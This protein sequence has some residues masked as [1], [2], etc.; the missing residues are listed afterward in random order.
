[1]K[2]VRILGA[3]PAGSIAA[4]AA[5]AEGARVELTERSRYPRH[6]VCGE[7]IS[8][9]IVPVLERLGLMD[10]FAGLQPFRVRRMA[11]HL[12]AREK[13]AVLP[14]RAFGLSRYA[15]DHLL[16]TSAFQAGALMGAGQPD[17]IAVGRHMP[18]E[19]HGGSLFGFKAHFDGP[20]DDAVEL[21]FFRDC[22]VGVNCVEGGRTNVCGLA[23]TRLLKEYAFNPEPLMER[24]R[25]LM[26]RLAPLSRV[27]EWM[28][29]GPLQFA[30][31]WARRDAFLAG[32]ALSFVDPF[33]GSGMLCAA[34][35]GELA[36]AHAARGL[37]VDAYIGACRREI[38]RPFAFAS[39]LRSLAGTSMAELLLPFV[40]SQ[41]LF[42]LTR[43]H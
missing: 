34:V 27:M 6:K 39:A 1:L 28:F 11:L 38:R 3:G 31:R 20:V 15:F 17:I 2:S 41:L 14:E 32:D 22:Y 5:L 29:V 13:L 16:W 7:F 4:V 25:A 37:S 19:A 24:S 33:T 23:P 8:P 30:Q 43:P 18:G 36:G 35:T 10:G 9:E 26:E 40:P 21:F 12:G 42:R